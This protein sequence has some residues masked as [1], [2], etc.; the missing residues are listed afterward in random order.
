VSDLELL[1]ND[2]AERSISTR[3]IVLALA[4]AER[5]IEVLG[6]SGRRLEA[7]EGW[8]RFPDGTR[9]RSLRHPGSFVLPA[10]GTRAAA[11]TLDSIR[12][13]QS[14]WDRSPEYPGASLYY[15]LTVAPA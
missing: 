8:V 7:W 12:K 11:V 6:R 15:C 4:D 10:D 3:D 5:A 2:L 14:V 1:P 13:A 9:T